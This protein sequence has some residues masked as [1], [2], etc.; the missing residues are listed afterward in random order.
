MNGPRSFLTEDINQEL[1]RTPILAKA[2][3]PYCVDF[4]R[5]KS[6]GFV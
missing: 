6:N 1:E 4:L 2:N 3:K 5:I